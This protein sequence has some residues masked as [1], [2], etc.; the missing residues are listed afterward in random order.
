M[1]TEATGH[2]YRLYWLPFLLASLPCSFRSL[3]HI[4]SQSCT[5]ILNPDLLLK[6]P[7]EE[8]H[9]A[10]CR[11]ERTER[12]DLANGLN[13]S[14]RRNPPWFWET[15]GLS[16]FR[17]CKQFPTS[18]STYR[19]FSCNQCFA[20]LVANLGKTCLG[21][22]VT[23]FQLGQELTGVLSQAFSLNSS[24]SLRL[25]WCYKTSYPGPSASS[26]SQFLCPTL[27][28]SSA[29]PSLQC[30]HGSWPLTRGIHHSVETPVLGLCPETSIPTSNSLFSSPPLPL[31]VL[32]SWPQALLSQ[33][34]SRWYF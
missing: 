23:S 33:V 14:H 34:D 9:L 7:R 4:T 19:E 25:P 24:L 8:K 6:E 21:E 16:L 11:V 13:G 10:I 15:F 3:P 12:M 29:T 28:L 27:I 31:P 26:V 2:W 1:P 5:Q 20:F 17:T 32:W 18:F 30:T 22:Y